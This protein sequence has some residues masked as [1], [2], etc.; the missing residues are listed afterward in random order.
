MGVIWLIRIDLSLCDPD[1]ELGI[2]WFASTSASSHFVERD[3][4]ALSSGS[5]GSAWRGCLYRVQQFAVVLS[6]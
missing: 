6:I 1:L 3:L 4:E 5:A 2:A